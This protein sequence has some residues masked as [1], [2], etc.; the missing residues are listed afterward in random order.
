MFSLTSLYEWG[1]F[2]DD[3]RQYVIGDNIVVSTKGN[4]LFDNCCSRSGHTESM[5][6]G[7]D[8]LLILIEVNKKHNLR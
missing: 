8:L 6:R 7:R 2:G 5:Y 3:F 1:F 4:T